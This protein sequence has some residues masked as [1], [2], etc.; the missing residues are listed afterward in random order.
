MSGQLLLF[1][2][3]IISP[4]LPGLPHQSV[5]P[6][7]QITLHHGDLVDYQNIGLGELLTD[8]LAMSSL[9]Q[10]LKRLFERVWPPGSVA[11]DCDPSDIECCYAG[12]CHNVHLFAGALEPLDECL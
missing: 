4:A 9:E 11:K 3:L 2:V 6:T 1:W 7:E 10:L 5:Q 8:L 12:W